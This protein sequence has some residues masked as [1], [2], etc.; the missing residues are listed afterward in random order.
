[1]SAVAIE[2]ASAPPGTLLPH[3][4]LPG[5]MLTRRVDDARAWTGASLR[6]EDWTV[7]LPA[8]CL[9]ELRAALAEIRGNR[10]PMFL[11]SPDQFA[12]ARCRELMAAYG[13]GPADAR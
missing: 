10:L 2:P 9:A 6:P 1:M 8:P 3:T 12:L 4:M 11:L 7:P 5:T 13:T